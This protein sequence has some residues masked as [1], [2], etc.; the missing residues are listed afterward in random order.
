MKK[1]G[2]AVLVSTVLATLAVSSR[3]NEAAVSTVSTIPSSQMAPIG[4]SSSLQLLWQVTD[5]SFSG[6]ITSTVTSSTGSFRTTCPTGTALGTVN[7]PL[8]RTQ[9]T[10]TVPCTSSI[11]ESVLVP[12]DI[13]TRANK[14][15]LGSI[16]YQR[17]F[18]NPNDPGPQTGFTTISI[19]SSTAAGL[20]ISR[21]ALSFDNR[22][23]T[24][25]VPVQQP[26][27]AIAEI[28]FSGTGLLKAVWE[29]A[30]PEST[31]GDPIFRPLAQVEQYLS[32]GDTHTF[33]SPLLPTNS[34]GVYLVR[35][36]ITDPALT[37]GSP[38][39]RYFVSEGRPG[40]ELPAEPLALVNPPPA[41]MLSPATGFSW[42]AI[43]GARAYQLEIFATGR[44]PASELPTLGAADRAPSAHDI[45]QALSR[46]PVTGLIVPA[47]QTRTP[48]TPAVRQHL[49]PGKAYLWRVL[50]I[51]ADGAVIG[52][53]P[54]RELRTP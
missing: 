6:P 46:P 52:Q 31:V 10:S 13:L 36:R 28:S 47:K 2:K 39:I 16:C 14:L 33:K 32:L 8:T 53:S 5:S 51:G 19:T 50:A 48:L 11:N 30:G 25:I 27:Q 20:G 3:E 4:I 54:M 21:E 23:A 22:A 17:T 43:K 38:V 15:G 9:G 24:R 26:L 12:A 45:M 29:A 42:D 35:L 1:P 7:V 37:F 41:A 40:K 49:E 44:D 18:E 34:A